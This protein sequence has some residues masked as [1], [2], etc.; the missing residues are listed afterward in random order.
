MVPSLARQAII[1]KC[2]NDT[3]VITGN[4]ELA[5]AVG[6]ISSQAAIPFPENYTGMKGLHEEMLRALEGKN[7]E[8]VHL[9]RLYRMLKLY[10]P[11][12]DYDEQMEEL[13]RMGREEQHPWDMFKC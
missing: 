12:E 13:I 6:V 3:S 11:T 5:Y 1:I 4:Y 10:H 9:K 8:D 2:G 7:L